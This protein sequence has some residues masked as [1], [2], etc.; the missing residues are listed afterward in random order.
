MTVYAVS[1]NLISFL[2]TH[3]PRTD[4]DSHAN[5]SCV[6]SNAYIFAFT[7]QY[8]KALGFLSTLG[9]VNKV[10]IVHAAVA[11]D[12]KDGRT[13]ILVIHQ[14]LYF[15]DLQH[16]LLYLNQ[17]R[18]NGVEVNDQPRIFTPQDQVDNCSHAIC[19]ADLIVPLSLYG[20]IPFFPSWKPSKNKFFT[21]D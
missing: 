10:P 20:I 4:L 11:Y 8:V 9:S 7:G 14:A 1:T 6:G 17:L 21:L 16:N 13:V 15:P 3:A 2:G 12:T 19:T 5:T 18:A